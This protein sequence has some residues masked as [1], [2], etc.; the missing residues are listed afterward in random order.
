MIIDAL[1]IAGTVVAALMAALVVQMFKS[2]KIRAKCSG[3]NKA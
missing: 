1:T 2:R 3:G